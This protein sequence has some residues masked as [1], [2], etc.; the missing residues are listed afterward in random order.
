[1]EHE[2]HR[3]TMPPGS[4]DTWDAVQEIHAHWLAKE[5]AREW[6]VDHSNLESVRRLGFNGNRTVAINLGAALYG[7]AMV[8]AHIAEFTKDFQKT[9]DV[10]EETVLELLMLEAQARGVDCTQSGRVAALKILL[11]YLAPAKVREK[12][13]T[14]GGDDEDDTPIVNIHLHKAA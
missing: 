5:F 10:D 4:P 2:T 13:L 3:F 8:Q 11:N 7:H 14:G 9:R 6:M 1:M 12:V